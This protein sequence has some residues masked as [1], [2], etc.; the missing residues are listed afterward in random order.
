MCFISLWRYMFKRKQLCDAC[1]CGVVIL[2]LSI[3]HHGTCSV[4]FFETVECFTWILSFWWLL[5]S[6]Q[7]FIFFLPAVGRADMTYISYFQFSALEFSL[8]NFNQPVHTIVIRSM[9]IFLKTLKLL[10]IAEFIVPSLGSTVNNSTFTHCSILLCNNSVRYT[11]SLYMEEFPS[12]L[13]HTQQI[14]IW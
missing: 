11:Y 14:R 8:Y 2:L 9:I 12:V 10:H 3:V 4:W 13:L 5:N 6:T 7:H 1:N